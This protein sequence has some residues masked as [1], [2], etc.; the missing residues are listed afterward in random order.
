M[1]QV[2]STFGH[3]INIELAISSLEKE[4]IKKECIFAVPLTNRK[5]ERRFFDNIHNFDGVS[6]FN[7]GA[8][9]AIH[10]ITFKLKFALISI[11][12]PK[13][14]ERCGKASY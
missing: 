3:S 14:G 10:G 2:F 7:K 4:G 13:S 8:A 1:I 9:I 11:T 12:F 6:F 5:S